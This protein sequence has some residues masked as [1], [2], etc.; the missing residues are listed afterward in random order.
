MLL[1][2]L[3][4]IP[5]F[6]SGLFIG[7]VKIRKSFDELSIFSFDLHMNRIIFVLVLMQILCILL[8]DSKI[9][10]SFD[11]LIFGCD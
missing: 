10:N 3:F 4:G 2:I 7:L 9:D 11:A 1:L 6:L 5:N 8:I